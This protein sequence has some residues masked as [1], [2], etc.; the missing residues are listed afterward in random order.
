MDN[1]MFVG[2]NNYLGGPIGSIIGAIFIF[3]IGWLV[4]LAIGGLVRNLLAR[5]NVNQ[6]MNSST[7]KSYDVEGIAAK[8][9][10][11]FIFIMAIS[12]ALSMLN[13]TAVSAPFANMINQVLSFIPT[14]MGAA[15]IAVIGWV[16]ATIARTLLS[17][18][19]S[20]TSLDERLSEEAGVSPMS[21]TIS[22]VVYWIIL[23]F[24]LTIVLGQLGLDGL[25]APLTNMLDKIFDF[26][27]NIFL[28]CVIFGV[29]YVVAKIVRG[30]VTSVISS[31]NLQ[32]IAQNAGISDHTRIAN[33]VGTLAFLVI[34]ILSLISALDTLSIEV[35]SRPATNMLNQIMLAIPNVIAAVAILAIAY[36]V[37]KFVASIVSNLLE[38]TGVNELPAKVGLQEMLGTQTVSSIIG[39]LII[40]FTMLFASIEAANRLG[41]DR[42]SDL[43]T[44]FIAFGADIILGAVILFIGF[45]LANIIAKVVE[46]SEQ[47]SEFLANIVRIL[48]MGLVLAMGLR[49]MGIADSIVNL[50]FGLTLGAVAVAF[51][52]SFGLGGQEAA[53]RF[54]RRVQDKMDAECDKTKAPVTSSEAT[55]AA[56]N[57]VT[58]PAS[59]TTSLD[60]PKTNNVDGLFDSDDLK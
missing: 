26:I 13:L 12:G 5:A 29:G 56:V 55:N 25:F 14:L 37:V 1:S 42:V 57:T 38:N 23:L 45:W 21:Q 48:I 24:V 41:F 2:F 32:T 51:A 52:L 43:I 17:T 27:P 60:T 53:A 44:L 33:S 50:A 31:M 11:W 8:I 46:R 6:R 49:A 35:I 39:K 22:D 36:Y 40:F 10:F 54:L 47:G 18:A 9:V 59:T 15:A 30:I 7:G 58:S 4:A 34:I 3:V 20:K 28:A 16:V 19:L